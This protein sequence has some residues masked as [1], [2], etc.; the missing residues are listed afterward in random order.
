[1]SRGFEIETEL[2]IHALEL[3]MPCAEFPTHYRERP[4]SSTSKLRTFHDGSRILT[5]IARLIID[6]R[7]LQ[8]FGVAGGALI[9]VAIALALPLATEYAETGLVPRFPTAI[10]CSAMTIVGAL[11]ILARLIMDIVT[12]ARQEMKRLFYLSVPLRHRADWGIQ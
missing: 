11:S 7:P 3:R 8:F 10:L 2:S 5:L 12:K 4:I 1:M 9:L 6:E